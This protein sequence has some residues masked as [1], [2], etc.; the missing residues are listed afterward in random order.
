MLNKVSSRLF[1]GLEVRLR[2]VSDHDLLHAVLN[3]TSDEG[4]ILMTMLM[5]FSHV[6]HNT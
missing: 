1:E 5:S 6:Y 3:S 2:R 4:K